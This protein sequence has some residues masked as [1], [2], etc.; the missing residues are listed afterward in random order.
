M[1]KKLLLLISVMLAFVMSIACVSCAVPD[2]GRNDENAATTVRELEILKTDIEIPEQQRTS[3]IKAEY[4]KKNSGYRDD[5]EVVAIIGLE[6]DSLIETFN[7]GNTARL[8]V[9][10]YASS[11]VGR[12]QAQNL[13]SKQNALVRELASDGLITIRQC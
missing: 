3:R 9:G 7:D 1:R 8:S 2:L 12:R 10:E 11:G 4:L 6:G 5:D 13:V